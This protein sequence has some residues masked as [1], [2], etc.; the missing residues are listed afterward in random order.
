MAGQSCRYFLQAL[1]QDWNKNRETEG[2][3]QAAKQLGFSHRWNNA[4]Q[5]WPRAQLCLAGLGASACEAASDKKNHTG[6]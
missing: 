2:V 3:A 4:G 5:R 1:L 6:S